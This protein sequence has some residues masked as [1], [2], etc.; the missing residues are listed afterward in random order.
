M[1]KFG[2]YFFFCKYHKLSQYHYQ[3]SPSLISSGV[4]LNSVQIFVAKAK[5][6]LMKLQKVEKVK[7]YLP[8]K[9][10]L[11]LVE[12]SHISDLFVRYTN[13]TYHDHVKS[14]VSSAR[15]SINFE[16]LQPMT[17]RELNEKEK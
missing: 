14:E 11:V 10:I 6:N 12:F 5:S 2:S 4:H 1:V 8:P 17:S 7:F 9:E 13:R 3:I 15:P 16:I